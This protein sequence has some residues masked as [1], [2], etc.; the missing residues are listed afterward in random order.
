MSCKS[1]S[2]ILDKKSWISSHGSAHHSRLHY[3]SQHFWRSTVQWCHLSINRSKLWLFLDALVAFAMHQ[4]DLYSN[5]NSSANLRIHWALN[6]L[7]SWTQFFDK[8]LDLRPTFQE[9][10]LQ[11]FCVA[12][13]SSFSILAPPVFWKSSHLKPYVKCFTLLTKIGPITTNC[14]EPINE[15][16]H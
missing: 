9:P 10:I 12:V 16:H 1:S 13:G 7:R 6:D 15:G 2:C 14:D 5:F 8:E 3:D 11:K 4:A